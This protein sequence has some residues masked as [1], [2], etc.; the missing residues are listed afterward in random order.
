MDN[1]LPE[2]LKTVDMICTPGKG[3]L[4][5]DES[6]G[7]IG[8]RFDNIGLENNEENRKKYRHLLFSTNNLEK[9]ISGVITFEETLQTRMNGERL[10]TDLLR[11][12]GI[13]VGIKTDKGVT[14]LA[15]T[16]GETVTQGLDDLDKRCQKYYKLGARFAKWRDVLKID[17][18]CPSELSINQNAEVLARYASISQQNG[19]VPIVE[20]EIIMDGEHTIEKSAEITENV[21]SAVYRKLVEHHVVLEATLLKPNMVRHGVSCPKQASARDIGYYTVRTLQRSVPVAVPGVV[22]LSGGMSEEDASDALNEI[23]L[24]EGKKPWYLSFSYGRALQ[25]SV[26][27]E[28]HGEDANIER[29]QTMLCFRASMNGAAA[30]GK[31][32]RNNETTIG[33]SL[34]V[35]NYKY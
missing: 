7:T 34:H 31:Y 24:Y 8:K 14:P 18:N 19:L 1:F 35:K 13:I 10:L 30:L 15:G 6:T 11:D 29:A 16:D 21:L 28:W 5:A 25:H 17:A 9:Y 27:K 33:E 2:L 20:P 23:N 22:F 3:I 26:L 32:C 4:A 12:K